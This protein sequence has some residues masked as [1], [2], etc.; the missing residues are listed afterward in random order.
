MFRLFLGHK[1][2]CKGYCVK[3]FMLT[4]S[5]GRSPDGR[6]EG[7]GIKKKKKQRRVKKE[8]QT[9]PASLLNFH[10]F[11]RSAVDSTGEQ[12]IILD[13]EHQLLPANM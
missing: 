5:L 12:W 9:L 13:C 3:K 6:V 1:Y 7:L 11:A 4:N 8:R 2:P 10:Y